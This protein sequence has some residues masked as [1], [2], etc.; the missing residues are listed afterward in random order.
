MI[1]VGGFMTKSINLLHVANVARRD[2]LVGIV[3]TE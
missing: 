3:G 2:V 1:S